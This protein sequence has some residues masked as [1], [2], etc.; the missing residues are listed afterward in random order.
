M[1]NVA[2]YISIIFALALSCFCLSN[3]SFAGGDNLVVITC[4][5][6]PQAYKAGST[7]LGTVD[8]NGNE[9]TLASVSASITGFTPNGNYATLTPTN[10]NASVALPSGAVV[11]A[12]NTGTTP[13]SCSLTV[14]AGTA[15]ATQNIIQAASWFAFTVGA[16]T[17]M[18]CID[19]TGSVSN[20][21]VL[22]SGA[23]LPTG[24]GGGS[25]GGGGGGAVTV[26]DGADVTQGA[27]ADT[28]WISGSGSIVALEK[29][30][31]NA[32]LGTQTTLTQIQANTSGFL[33]PA[34]HAQTTAAA[35]FLVAKASAGNLISVSGSAASGSFIMLFDAT[36]APADGVVTPLKCWGPMA[37]AGPFVFSWGTG[38]VFGLNVGITLV[39]SSTGC[40]T[41]TAT[42]ASFISV[43][44]Q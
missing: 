40:F 3:P 9:C 36:S 44:Y 2:K 28:A 25:G 5:T 13:V 39:S 11:V 43:E 41:K 21:V 12:S 30:T 29:A 27:K 16:N 8:I 35:S 31:V 26:A 6:I 17:F 10:V 15:T 33:P 18:N 38:P 37:V 42:N 24:A 14:G 20:L 32:I 34:S 19:Q 22:S 1:Q 4:G 23:G 7:R